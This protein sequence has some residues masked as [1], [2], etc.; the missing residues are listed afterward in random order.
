MA[1][2]APFATIA[3]TPADLTI[4]SPGLRDVCEIPGHSWWRGGEHR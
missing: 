2:V 4:A 1:P 3:I